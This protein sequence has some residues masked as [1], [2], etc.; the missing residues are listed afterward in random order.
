MYG[1]FDDKVAS[2]SPYDERQPQAWV[3]ATHNYLTSR[4]YEM[5]IWLK[6]VEKFQQQKIT[7]ADVQSLRSGDVDPVQ[8][9]ARLWGYLN[10]ALK[11]SKL[12]TQFNNGETLNGF[13]AW[14][15]VIV[16]LKPRTDAK[17]NTLHSRVHNPPRA[18]SLTDIA[19]K[20]EDWEQ[21]V[22]EFGTC[23]GEVSA[24]DRMTVVMKL[25][26]ANTPSN[27]VMGLRE[28]SDFEMLKLKIQQEVEF[29]EEFGPKT[30][31]GQA[32]SFENERDG[33]EEGGEEPSFEDDTLPVINLEGMEEEPA[34]LILAFSKASGAFRTSG[35]PGGFGARGKGRGKGQV[36][37]P[38]FAGR[39]ATPP[40]T[41]RPPK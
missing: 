17:R 10:L 5:D 39:A 12:F 25:L 23:G 24:R 8:Q 13:E 18:T 32:H 2:T 36:K 27:L 38:P 19:N 1:I 34:K 35:K 40:P 20:L 31:N 21:L 33:P 11:G 9:S 6:W 14:R 15:R 30:G 28:C 29:L 7:Q 37:P 3:K 22:E 41:G 26:P 16:P 4:C